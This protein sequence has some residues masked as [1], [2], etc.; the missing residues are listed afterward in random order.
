MPSVLGNDLREKKKKYSN[1]EAL[2][3]TGVRE[4]TEPIHPVRMLEEP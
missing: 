2:V 1:K 4:A 3:W